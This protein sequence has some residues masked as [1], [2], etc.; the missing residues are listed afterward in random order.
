MNS[1]RSRL[2]AGQPGQRARQRFWPAR[3]GQPPGGG[4]GSAERGSVTIFVV[5]YTLV[6]LLLAALLVD[7][8]NAVNAQ[9]RAGDIAEQAARAAADTVDVADLRAGNVVIDQ[10]QACANASSLI[11]QY[12]TASKLH[13]A[14]TQPCTYP[15]ARQVTVYVSVTTTPLFSVFPS[16]TMNAHES[17]CAEFGVAQGEAC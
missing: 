6:A 16:F 11:Q 1:S 14:M 8:G 9:E 7:G 10:S 3:R 12:A 4:A 15:S 5:F 13:A 2:V 17:A